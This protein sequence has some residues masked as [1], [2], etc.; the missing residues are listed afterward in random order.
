MQSGYVSG[1][2][3]LGPGSATDDLRNLGQVTLSLRPW[4]LGACLL[5]IPV[6]NMALILCLA[7]NLEIQI[8][9][10]HCSNWIWTLLPVP[11]GP[12]TK[13]ALRGPMRTE[14]VMF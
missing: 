1:R 7:A 14:E 11:Q 5:H 12:P 6:E 10:S 8:H 9:E 2:G 3:R 4:I 13:W